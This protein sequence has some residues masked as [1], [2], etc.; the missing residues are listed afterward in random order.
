[1]GEGEGMDVVAGVALGD[2]VDVTAA[3][4][5]AGCVIRDEAV[6]VTVA[7]VAGVALGEVVLVLVEVAQLVM[8]GVAEAVVEG[9]TDMLGVE[10]DV[11]REVEEA[12][13]ELLGVT[14]A[15]A[16][17]VALEVI[18]GDGVGLGHAPNCWP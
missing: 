11:V 15:E 14:K 2:T 7:V 3:V 1:M 6:V 12:D 16:V 5:E 4:R 18:E 17:G 8:R 9:V 10:V 13:G